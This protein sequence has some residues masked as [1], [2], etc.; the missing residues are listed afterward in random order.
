MSVL[1]YT[2][3]A[4]EIE[5]MGEVV[6]AWTMAKDSST[7][8]ISGCSASVQTVFTPPLYLKNGRDNELTMVNRETYYSFASIR[9]DKNSLK[10]S[11]DSGK[12]WTALHIPTGGYELK[13]INVEIVRMNGGTS[14]ITI[15]PNVNTLHCILNV[16]E[17][18]LGFT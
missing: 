9:A 3:R 13:A 15:L 12:T 1:F 14:N 5:H 4:I 11:G 6:V 16:V 2:E 10:W 17:A 18:K 7:I 8:V